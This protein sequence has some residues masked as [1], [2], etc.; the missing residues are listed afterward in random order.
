MSGIAGRL[1]SRS[2]V[3]VWGGLRGLSQLEVRDMIKEFDGRLNVLLGSKSDSL[4]I[5]QLGKLGVASISVGPT[6]Q[7]D[8]MSTLV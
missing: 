1:V 7:I 4:T 3:L 2:T 5:P 6:L 8:A